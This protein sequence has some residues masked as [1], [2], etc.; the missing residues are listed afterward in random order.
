MTLS[1]F[2]LEGAALHWQRLLGGTAA[3]CL[4]S[5]VNAEPLMMQL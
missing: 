2:L 1:G 3:W 5:L 4:G